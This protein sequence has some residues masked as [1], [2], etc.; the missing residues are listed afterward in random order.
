MKSIALESLGCRYGLERRQLAQLAAI[1]CELQGDERAPTTIRAP[2]QAADIHLADS[3]TALELGL[4]CSGRAIA[5]LGSG[6][7]FP[8]VALA[9]ALPTAQV[10]LVESQR[11]KC[12][13]LKRLCLAAEIQNV[14]V[15][16]TRAEEWREGLGEQDVIVA[17]ALAPQPV[18]LEYAAPLLRVGGA[19]VDWR[20]RRG[21]REESAAACAAEQLGLRLAEIRHTEPYG[22]ARDHHLHVYEKTGETPARFPRRSGAARK[23]PLGC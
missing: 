12:E 4:V 3:L 11:R 9:V 22:G 7:G 17:R 14:R 15:V 23:R 18:V 16:C 20:G 5:D 21:A 19:L 10:S 8:G 1:L 6:A 2:E 13:F